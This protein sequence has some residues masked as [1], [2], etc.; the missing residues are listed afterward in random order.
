MKS[1]LREGG[2]SPLQIATP[3]IIYTYKFK[4][5]Q[6]ACNYAFSA[7]QIQIFSQKG[8]Q[9]WTPSKGFAHKPH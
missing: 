7:H 5:K 1:F 6:R 8:A 9:P 4:V 3:E 2:S